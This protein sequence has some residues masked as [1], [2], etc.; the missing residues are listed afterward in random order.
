MADQRD[1]FRVRLNCVDHYQ[2]PPSSLD[3]PLWGP[4][5]SLTQRT[6][7][8]SVPVI[9]VFGSTETGQKVCAHIHGAFPYLFVPYTEGLGKDEVER[10]IKTL[11]D[12]IDHAL[13]LSYRRNPYD[14]RNATFVAHISLVKGVPFFGYHVGYRHFLKIY[15][16]NPQHMTRFTDLLQQGAIM[17][18][19]FQ[20]Y[21]AHLQYLLQWMCDFNLYGCAYIELDAAK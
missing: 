21:E 2:H 13:A 5:S 16:L 8:P 6:S 19:V 10:Y 14:P 3:P 1:I 18:Q 7:L 4:S 20:P 17:K 11:R 15:L 9:R 12:S